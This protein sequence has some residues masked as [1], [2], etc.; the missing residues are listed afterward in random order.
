MLCSSLQD[1]EA[2]NAINSKLTITGAIQGLEMPC[3]A[4]KF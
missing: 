3:N 4:R 2:G 1:I